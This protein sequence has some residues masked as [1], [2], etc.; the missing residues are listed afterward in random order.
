MKIIDKLA[1]AEPSF[2]FEFFPP[3][4]AAGVDQLFHHVELLKD[5]APTFVS[6]TWG[7][8]G[9]TRRLTVELVKRIHHEVGIEAMAHL[10]CVGA[11]RSELGEVLSD[12]QAAGI[13]NILALRG[14]PPKGEAVFVPFEGGFA[15]ASDLTAFIRDQFDLCVGGACYPETHQEAPDADTDLAHLKIKAD[16]GSDFFVTQMF[17]DNAHY[18]DFVGRAR[19]AGIQQPIIPGIM[20]I[21]NLRQIER[22]TK[23]C[24]AKFPGQLRADLNAASGSAEELRAVGV[25]HA[26]RQCMDLLERGAP[27]IHFYTLN[28]SKATTRVLRALKSNRGASAD[29]QAS[30]DAP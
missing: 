8:G 6:V 22:M 14:D 26:T 15:H 9:S 1:S 24:G 27:G 28:R 10:T 4:D 3:K 19:Q 17:F 11:S 5:L 13:E 20:P 7:A 16:A 23:M 25:D 21:T 18:Y 29:W 30:A 2:S 12:L